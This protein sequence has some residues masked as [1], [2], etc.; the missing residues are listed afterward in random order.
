VASDVDRV[1]VC[2]HCERATA[3]KVKGEAVW[4]GINREG[5]HIDP[6]TEWTL[7]QCGSCLL[8]S[9]QLREDYGGG[10]EDDEPIF[11]YPEPRRLN[12]DIPIALRREWEEAKTCLD[13]KAYAACAVM[14]RR[15]LEG[16]C[17]ELGVKEKNLAKALKGLQAKGLIDGMLAEWA[18]ALRVAGN[19]GAH[20][21]GEPVSREDAENSLAFTEA[22]LDHVY[23]LRKRFEEFKRRLDK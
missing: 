3:A 9:L 12:P 14:T 20:F 23:V 6:P 4:S 5:E 21:T 8:P 18:K 19:R 11:V 16:T 10:F 13:A 15:T 7:V 1:I 22:L 17:K 2:P